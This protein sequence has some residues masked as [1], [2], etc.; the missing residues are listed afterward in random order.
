[1]IVVS[2]PSRSCWSGAWQRC[3]SPGGAH[4][5]THSILKPG[6]STW[7][8]G[9][10]F[11]PTDVVCI[12]MHQIQNNLSIIIQALTGH[13]RWSRSDC[14][15]LKPSQYKKHGRHRPQISLIKMMTSQQ[16][17]KGC[18]ISR[19]SSLVMEHTHSLHRGQAYHL[20][21]SN[22]CSSIT[23]KHPISEVLLYMRRWPR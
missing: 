12:H 17:A 11:Y 23:N 13:S 21:A 14:C 8:A 2:A 6:H 1:M 3:E 15:H 16:S 20:N 19:V 7:L 10:S 22:C 5:L 4:T 18:W 9:V